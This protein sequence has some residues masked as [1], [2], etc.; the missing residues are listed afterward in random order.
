MPGMDIPSTNSGAALPW[1]RGDVNP[2]E[3]AA[4]AAVAPETA[5]PLPGVQQ[6]A[7]GDSAPKVPNAGD[8]IE[9]LWEVH[10]PDGSTEAKWWGA[11]VERPDEGHPEE[12]PEVWRLRYD[13]MGDFEE[14]VVEVVFE[15][16]G[17][18]REA[19]DVIGGQMQWKFEGEDVSDWEEGEDAE[20]GPTYT[21]A[22]LMAMTDDVE[23][24]MGMSLDDALLRHLNENVPS[25]AARADIAERFRG[26]LDTFKERI[27]DR[28]DAAGGPYT[29]TAD[30]VRQIASQI[31]R[32]ALG[33][34]PPPPGQS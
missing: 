29:V 1:A 22:E 12:Q 24:H 16:D 4:A 10:S 15:D 19:A 2:A 23:A 5:G 17:W 11:V 32:D 20:A 34:L 9:V 26:F 31:S 25:A 7:E 18:L 3:P 33:N 21:P 30:D 8:R 6:A 27:N 28:I 13:A 14:E